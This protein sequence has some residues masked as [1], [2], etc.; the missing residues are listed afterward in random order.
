[1]T[2]PYTNQAS[3][4]RYDRLVT[5]EGKDALAQ[6]ASR[7]PPGSVVLDVGAATGALGRFLS[8]RGSF[9]VDGIERE[10]AA[11]ARA[12]PFYRNVFEIDLEQE[13][14]EA[15]A[16]P[17][18]FIVCADVLEHL[19]SP[20]RALAAL[21]PHLAPGG[22][23]LISVPN[24]GY[25][26]LLAEILSGDFRYRPLGLLDETHLR[27][28]TRSSMRE[29]LT[30]AGLTIIAEGQVELELSD[31]EFA[32]QIHEALPPAIGKA[33]LARPDA[34]SYQLIFEASNAPGAASVEAPAPAAL[35]ADLH[36]GAQIF[37]RGESEDHRLERC[38]SSRGV[39]GRTGQTLRFEI[40]PGADV[41][42]LRWDI[43]DRPAFID[44]EYLQLMNLEGLVMR[45]WSAAEIAAA[46]EA[47]KG[48]DLVVLDPAGRFLATGPDPYVELA[49]SDS[50]RAAVANGA[51]VE[52]RV[53]TPYS[54]DFL[55][56]AALVRQAQAEMIRG[57]ASIA[58]QVGELRNWLKEEL[59]KELE[60]HPLLR[61]MARRAELGDEQLQELRQRVELYERH[62]QALE[63]RA[64]LLERRAD[65]FERDSAGVRFWRLTRQTLASARR[66][67]A[68]PL[69]RFRCAPLED[70]ASNAAGQHE[71]RSPGGKP[72]LELL[73]ELAIAPRGWCQ[74]ELDVDAEFDDGR[75]FT[76]YID[77]GHG[78][79]E[80]DA[81]FLAP[82]AGAFRGIVR[83]PDVVK[84]LRLDPNRAGLFSIR[85]LQIR[86]VGKVE[87]AAR[88]AAPSIRAALEAPHRIPGTLSDLLRRA[89][90][91]GI[92]GLK[93]SITSNA[94]RPRGDGNDD[95]PG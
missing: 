43:T 7:I 67:M 6:L 8:E 93:R 13:T 65:L 70:V 48:N 69:H 58:G 54:P 19:T 88:L 42:F 5:T 80:A 34:L 15:L 37:W 11:A 40:P 81:I 78:F 29:L 59:R 71:W 57:S 38:V 39:L 77:Q 28:F 46:I 74:L 84:R 95:S 60:T 35:P 91:E 33:L 3:A 23:I 63:Q 18:D 51:A 61:A 55:A 45:R 83:L 24:I 27:F 53:S 92:S 2:R 17:Y 10:P 22:R 1:M 56:A 30:N 76:L 79:S 32:G 25:A 62:L 64:N 68:R 21:T 9:V 66:E 49:V 72:A 87:A 36:F 50:A 89:R 20:R 86:E 44:S 12:R 90:A 94:L 16:G 82:V 52:V 14:V 85:T 26:G 75:P 31:S 47:G 73:S 4:L 41:R